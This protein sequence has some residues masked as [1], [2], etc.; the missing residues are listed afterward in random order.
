MSLFRPSDASLVRGALA[1]QADSFEALVSR[2]QARAH[3]IAHAIGVDRGGLDDVAQEAFLRAFRS[4]PSLESPSRFGPWLYQIVRNCARK[5]LSRAIASEPAGEAVSGH[6]PALEA[7]E[8]EEI[9]ERVRVKLA[10]M[11]TELREVIFLYYYEGESTREVARALGISRAAVK[12][13]L[14]RGRDMLRIE[15]WRDL[16][17]DLRDLLPSA[18]DWKKK[19][20]Q[21]TIAVLGSIPFSA[22]GT[23]ASTASVLAGSAVTTWLGRL[24][25]ASGTKAVVASAAAVLIGLAGLGIVAGTS[26]RR[27]AITPRDGIAARTEFGADKATSPGPPLGAPGGVGESGDRAEA[28]G[29]AAKSQAAL[30]R[31]PSQPTAEIPLEVMPEGISLH[32]IDRDGDLDL[33]VAGFG[34][35]PRDEAGN[36]IFFS[37]KGRF[38][39]ASWSS[40]DTGDGTA[41]AF[42]DLDRDGDDDLVIARMNHDRSVAYRN[43]GKGVLETEPFW[44]TDD[45]EWSSAAYVADFDGDRHAD[46]LLVG[47]SDGHRIYRGG[48]DGPATH[49]DWSAEKTGWAAGKSVLADVDKDGRKDLLISCW[50]G[51]AWAILRGLEKDFET[52]ASMVS[53]EAGEYYGLAAGDLNG[54][55][56]PE[57]AVGSTSHRGGDGRIRLYENIEGRPGPRAVWM[58]ED[59]DSSAGELAF[60]DLDGDGDLD[61]FVLS[62]NHTCVHMNQGGV[63]TRQPGWRARIDGESAVIADLDKD[64]LPDLVVAGRS[65]IRVFQGAKEPDAGTVEPFPALPALPPLAD[66]PTLAPAEVRA[67][68]EPILAG[69]N[70]LGLFD[71]KLAALTPDLAARYGQEAG[72]GAVVLAV[73]EEVSSKLGIGNLREGDVLLGIGSYMEHGRVVEPIPDPV[74][75]LDLL[76]AY[77]EENDARIAELHWRCGPLHPETRGEIRQERLYMEGP[78]WMELTGGKPEDSE[79][80]AAIPIEG[81][82]TVLD[83]EGN[84][85]ANESGVFELVL[86]VKNT[87]DIH[88][89]TVRNGK[90][91]AEAPPSVQ[92]GVQGFRLGGRPAYV[93]EDRVPVPGDGTLHIRARWAPVARLRVKAADTGADLTGIEVVSGRDFDVGDQ[94]HPGPCSPEDVVLADARSPIEFGHE[95]EDV[96]AGTRKYWVR[97]PGYAWGRIAIDHRSGGERVLVLEPAAGVEV[98]LAGLRPGSRAVVRLRECIEGAR[99]ERRSLLQ[100]LRRALGK[101]E[102]VSEA[103]LDAADVDLEE[104]LAGVELTP[105]A[106]DILEKMEDL[107]TERFVVEAAPDADGSARIEGVAPGRYRLTVEIGSRWRKPAALAEAVVDLGAGEIERVSLALKEPPARPS[108]VPVAGTLRVPEAWGPIR[109]RIRLHARDADE[110]DGDDE[111]A[112][113]RRHRLRNLRALPV[114]GEPEVLRWDAGK[115]PPGR[116]EFT[117]DDVGYGTLIAV[118]P[119]G[120]SGMKLELPEPVDREIRLVDVETGEEARV[121]TLQ[122]SLAVVDGFLSSIDNEVSR[123]ERMGRFRFRAPGGKLRLRLDSDEYSLDDGDHEIHAG[124]SVLRVRRTCGIRLSVKEGEARVPWDWSWGVPRAREVGGEGRATSWGE[125]SGAFRVEVTRPGTYELSFPSIRGYETIPSRRIEVKPGQFS[126]AIVDLRRAN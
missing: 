43:T 39:S 85:H 33:A 17:Q 56:F 11:P 117:V 41:A 120:D 75:L 42:G 84:E 50:M 20:R 106:R 77:G 48:K 91:T 90:W 115:L 14:Q 4:L 34:R 95:E 12:K 3:G 15:L 28:P 107:N 24:M 80:P 121:N 101:V 47:Y 110:G 54:D 97:A 65:W 94:D 71:L 26:A 99:E 104:K 114:E 122:W 102:G 5:Y 1:G 112:E 98:S 6:A 52:R 89:V 125:K 21:V 40:S 68:P 67:S 69:K 93:D 96:K 58:S 38:A 46:V 87:G 19:A 86:W 126:E 31:L 118:G 81:T 60:E 9:R 18:R 62:G 72:S 105:M 49:A 116:Y 51:P 82:L 108:P 7:L 32:D 22:G 45:K 61:L 37:E 25:A 111:T 35:G 53:K 66:V 124:E 113:E 2:H 27:E 8:Q 30:V 100:E 92:L 79:E 109:P 83:L 63:L 103:S 36:L 13:R 29:E 76:Q 70:A 73:P 23:G 59:L 88:E 74:K 57:I 44:E 78:R 10:E 123:D 55:G 64:G 16:E 119:E